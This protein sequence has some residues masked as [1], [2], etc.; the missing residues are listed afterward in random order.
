MTLV[1]LAEIDELTGSALAMA[2]SGA[3]QYG[4]LLNTWKAIMNRPN[5]FEA[6]LPFLRS[7]AGPGPLDQ[8]IKDTCALYVGVLNHCRYTVSHRSTSALKNGADAAT[9]VKMA[10]D[11]WADFDSKM[12]TALEF[13]KELTLNPA[14]VEYSTLPQAV[15]SDVLRDLKAQFNDAEIVD[16]AMTVSV[17]NALA[18]F[19]R[20]MDF[21]QDMPDAPEGL[22]PR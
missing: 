21:E 5:L 14:Q 15:S 11:E 19:H 18:R 12:R 10:T 16:L 17:W 7:V 13:T 20:V 3:A 9:L 22:D 2:E 6:Y 4:K 1:R 8:A